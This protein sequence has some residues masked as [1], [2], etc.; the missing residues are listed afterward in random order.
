MTSA[1]IWGMYCQR[2][3][4]PFVPDEVAQ[5]EAVQWPEDFESH[6]YEKT[7]TLKSELDALLRKYRAR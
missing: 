5:L 7:E 3:E 1:T 2:E 4:Q 6:I